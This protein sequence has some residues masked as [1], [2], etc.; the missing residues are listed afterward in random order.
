MLDKNLSTYQEFIG[1]SIEV[2]VEEIKQ[3]AESI[4]ESP[5]I[6]FRV[7]NPETLQ[8]KM[9]IKNTENIF[10]I[11]DVYG[12]RIIVKSV[13]E[14]Y[15]VLY[16]ISKRFS[17][18]VDHDY[19]KEP[20]MCVSEINRGKMLRLLQFIAYKNSVP[21]EIQIT[22]SAFHEMNETLHEGYK[23]NQS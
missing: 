10:T 23:K 5:I 17:G 22:T 2:L 14:A 15:L 6:T 19:I 12:I 9:R 8:K 16:K 4:A 21:F 11:D 1:C 7:K 3:I 13:V 20:R 18:Y